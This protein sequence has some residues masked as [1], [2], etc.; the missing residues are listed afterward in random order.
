[1]LLITATYQQDPIKQQHPFKLES[2]TLN[3]GVSTFEWKFN[4][5]FLFVQTLQEMCKMDKKLFQDTFSFI[6]KKHH[7]S[8]LII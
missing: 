6:S 1:M 5:D 4:Y 8:R 7:T 3:E 2:V